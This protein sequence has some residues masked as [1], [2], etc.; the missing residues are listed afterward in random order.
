MTQRVNSVL[1]KNT[2]RAISVVNISF[3]PGTMLCRLLKRNRNAVFHS[4]ATTSLEMNLARPRLETL[5]TIV[6]SI[7]TLNTLYLSWRFTALFAGWVSPGTGLCSWTDGIDCDK[8]LQTPQA[9]A[10]IVPNAILGFGFFSG[11]L[12]WWLAGRRLNEAHRHHLTRT[13]A[14]WLGIASL[15]TFVF[16]TLLFRLNAL[17]PFCPW[18]HVLTYVAFVLALMIWRTTPKTEER[19]SLKSLLLLVTVCVAW[20]WLWQ[21]GWFLAE[22]TVLSRE[23]TAHGL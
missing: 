5:L 23:R 10:F 15:F 3:S 21:V 9:R 17:C 1:S 4:F 18:N 13:L 19:G 14:F 22:F 20:F 6:L 11:A 12:I 2:F 8:V 16:W 7:T